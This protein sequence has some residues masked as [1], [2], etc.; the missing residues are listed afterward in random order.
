[1][2]GGAGLRQTAIAAAVTIK[3]KGSRDGDGDG[4]GGLRLTEEKEGS[5]D[6]GIGGNALNPPTI[7]DVGHRERE[8]LRRSHVVVQQHGA[9]DRVGERGIQ[10]GV[11]TIRQG[12]LVVVVVAPIRGLTFSSLMDFLAPS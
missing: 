7:V 2:L 12:I 9:V 11:R 4:H 6:L 8:T 10:G 3:F 5:G 1:M